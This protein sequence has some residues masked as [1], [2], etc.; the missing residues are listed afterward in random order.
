MATSVQSAYGVTF[1]P[2]VRAVLAIFE[3]F[4]LNLFEFGLPLN[5]MGLGSFLQRLVMML[6]APLCLVACAPPTAFWLLREEGGERSAGDVLLRALPMALRLLFVVFPLVSAVAVQAF[7]C[8]G[9]DDGTYWLRADY[10]LQCG[11]GDERRLSQQ[12]D[13]YT[14]V[15]VAAL[16]AILCYPVGVPLAFLLLLLACRKQ[17]SRK[18]PS[19]PLS[20]ALGFLCAE[21]RK[22]WFAWEVPPPHRCALWLSTPS[23]AALLTSSLARPSLPHNRTTHTRGSVARDGQEALLRLSGAPRFAGHAHAAARG[24]GG[25]ALDPRLPAHRRAV[26]ARPSP[27]NHHTHLATPLTFRSQPAP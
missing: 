6:V 25:R 26:Q 22:R 8:E 20:A 15:L 27:P 3:L 16:F 12:T 24:A 23:L 14:R 4:S 13:E 2:A 9:F 1:P 21:Y 18:A 5:C 19:T 10:S 7:D 17:L 11:W